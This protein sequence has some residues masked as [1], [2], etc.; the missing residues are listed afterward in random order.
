MEASAQD[1]IRGAQ[2]Y[3]RLP[4]DV[5]SCVTCH[6]PDPTQG[7]NNV[8]RAAD[9]P[10]ALLKALNDV[11]AMGFLK[12][13]LGGTDVVELAAYLGRVAAVANPQ[14]PVGVWPPTVEF[15]TFSSGTV[16]P[17]H[18]VKLE[19]RGGV[20]WQ[21]LPPEIAAGPFT[22]VHDCPASLPPGGRCE[23]RLRAEPALVG[24]ST[25]VLR[26]TADAAWSPLLVGLLVAARDGGVPALTALSPDAQLQFPP[27]A[28]GASHTSSWTL[29]ST[30]TQPATLGTATVSGPQAS[31]FGITGDCTSGRVLAPSTTCTIQLTHQPVVALRSR[32]TLQVRSNGSNPSTLELVGDARAV[33]E[34]APPSADPVAP[35]AGGGGCAAGPA[36]NSRFDPTLLVLL[37]LAALGRRARRTVTV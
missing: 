29:I 11:G 3:L 8:L 34:P 2:L 27:V 17:V 16:S 36:A 20:A 1:G 19:N 18:I 31:E 35:G 25:G 37:A 15:G 30:G 26:F 28:L 21:V 4:G 7:R 5:P 12:P 6:G 14:G 13:V 24:S 22:L 32:A 9:N 23:A 10:A 33:A